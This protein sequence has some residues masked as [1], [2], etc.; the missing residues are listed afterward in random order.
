MLIS[1]D[2]K[3]LISTIFNIAHD[4]SLQTRSIPK[5]GSIPSP[6]FYMVHSF[7]ILVH[8]LFL[9]H[10]CTWFIPSPYFYMVHSFSVLVQGSFLLRAIE[11]CS[12]LKR[13]IEHGSF[14]IH[15]CT[16]YLYLNIVHS[17]SILEH[18]SFLI[19]IWTLIIP[20]LCLNTVHSFTIFEHGSNPSPYLN[21]IHPYVILEHNKFRL[22][23]WTWLVPSLYI[24]T[25]HSFFYSFLIYFWTFFIPSLCLNTVHSF[26]IYEHGSVFEHGS[27]LSPYLNTIYRYSKLEHNKFLL[28]TWTWFWLIAFF[29]PQLAKI[30][31]L[32]FTT[33]N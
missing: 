11:Q 19:V 6:Y 13:T 8:G 14:L 9:L 12:F 7:S 15:T 22:R 31:V 25:V 30:N 10:T 27:I 2:F 23:T 3:P 5:H 16:W 29:L 18:G 21:A 33:I 4:I 24:N 17:F 28:R 1:T 32:I 26:F 20:S